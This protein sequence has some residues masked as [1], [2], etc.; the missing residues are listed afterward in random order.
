M[1]L[2]ENQVGRTIAG[3][4]LTL[5]LSSQSYY[6]TYLG[7]KKLDNEQSQRADVRY[8]YARPLSSPE[9]KHQ[10]L[11][12]AQQLKALQHPSI[13]PIIDYGIEEASSI[14]YL[15]SDFVSFRSLYNRLVRQSPRPIFLEEAL[16]IITHVGEALQYAHEH[17][18]VH[19]DLT[20]H[21]IFF[22]VSNQALLAGFGLPVLQENTPR[23]HSLSRA[24]DQQSRKTVS[25]DISA[26]ANI[27][28]TMLTGKPSST[29]SASHGS[30][31]QAVPIPLS[32]SLPSHISS[33]I[34]TARA[35]EPEQRFETV[36]QFLTALQMPTDPHEQPPLAHGISQGARCSTDYHTIVRFLAVLC[37]C[38]RTESAQ[39]TGDGLGSSSLVSACSSPSSTAGR[40]GDPFAHYAVAA[41]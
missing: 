31:S 24:P 10:F 39:N 6:D 35:T 20:S 29:S 18:I 1:I 19:G 17:N 12:E 30:H 22:N 34:T 11:R 8:F 23:E 15:I 41:A 7:E 3:Y 26:L 33:A 13:L 25:A 16:G 38:I 5:Q 9:L 28:L 2:S 37:V 32:L 21:N 4:V 14:P 36:K 27:F 40:A